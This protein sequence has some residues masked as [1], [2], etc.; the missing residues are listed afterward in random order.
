[1]SLPM[2]WTSAGQ[3]DGEPGLVGPVADGGD[4]VQQGVEPDVDRLLGVERDGDAPGEPLPADRD[5]LEAR[6]DEADDLVPPA[7]GLDEVGVGLV[8]GEQAVG[9][10]GEAEEVILLLDPPELAVRVVRAP[11]VDDLLLGLERLAA[12][13]VEAGVR[14]LV[15]VARVVDGLDELPAADV[16]ALLARSG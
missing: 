14:L 7:L 1:M 10:G 8:V 16:V 6:L 11:A 15:D 3:V 5:V 2:T 13:A 12:V 9:E 4:V